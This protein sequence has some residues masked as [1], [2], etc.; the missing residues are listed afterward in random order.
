LTENQIEHLIAGS[1]KGG[2]RIAALRIARATAEICGRDAIVTPVSP[3]IRRQTWWKN[4]FRYR[5]ETVVLGWG[6]EETIL[7]EETTLGP[8]GNSLKGKTVHLHC[9]YRSGL[10]IEDIRK[11]SKKSN[12]I[13]TIHDTRWTSW[14]GPAGESSTRPTKKWW[15]VQTSAIG[16]AL[17]RVRLTRSLKKI[18]VV[19]PSASAQ[20][21]AVSSGLTRSIR[22]TVI[23]NPVPQELFDFVSSK[24]DSRKA[25]GLPQTKPVILFTAWQAWKATGDLNKGYDL[26]EQAIPIAREKQSFSF[27]IFGHNGTLIPPKLGAIWIEPDGSQHQVATIMRAADFLVAASRTEVL[28]TVVQEAHALGLPA[29]VPG[30]TGYVDVVTDGET[31]LYFNPENPASL[32]ERI[33]T[34]IECPT[35]RDAMGHAAAARAKLLW[36]PSV[37]APD[38]SRVYGGHI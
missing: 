3:I 27:V 30:A 19:F 11:I 10:R 37:I 5:L 8:L 31:G 28:P 25:L 16:S 6:L 36:H 26:L 29:V 15:K 12:V 1:I 9:M 35:R 7:R 17:L 14:S 20:A 32:A 24:S 18:T 2:A 13:W 22:H 33:V 23:A 34:M 38:Y 21:L 4:V